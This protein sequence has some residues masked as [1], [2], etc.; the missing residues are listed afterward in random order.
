MNDYEVI[1]YQNY[2]F[3]IMNRIIYSLNSDIEKSFKKRIVKPII[4]EMIKL[5]K[6][7]PGKRY[8][9]NNPHT[10]LQNITIPA[11]VIRWYTKGFFFL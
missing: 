4:I 8:R 9:S 2:L 5:I 3:G 7:F 10:P 6:G 1:Y 11:P